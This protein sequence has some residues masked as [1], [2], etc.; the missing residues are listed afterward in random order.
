[1]KFMLRTLAAT[2]IVVLATDA[3]QGATAGSR[4]ATASSGLHDKKLAEAATRLAHLQLPKGSKP[5][6]AS[7]NRTAQTPAAADARKGGLAAAAG[8]KKAG[9][10]AAADAKKGGLAA[11]AGALKGGGAATSDA[12]KAGAA[13][14]ARVLA[15]VPAARVPPPVSAPPALHAA[16]AREGTLSGTGI[17][18]HPSAL[19]ALGGAETGKSTGLIGGTSMR[20]KTR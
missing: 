4:L 9:A 10:A 14:A 5:K 6:V 19:A 3:G 7:R 17:K 11:A 2:A 15:A 1:M 12:K 20:P 13:A 18:P 8:A 16:A